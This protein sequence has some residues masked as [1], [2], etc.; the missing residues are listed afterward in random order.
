MSF[1]SPVVAT[2]ACC[3]NR[4]GIPYSLP[5]AEQQQGGAA[6]GGSAKRCILTSTM[7]TPAPSDTTVVAADWAAPS[8]ERGDPLGVCTNTPQS[9][10]LRLFL[11][12]RQEPLDDYLS[13]ELLPRLFAWALPAALFGMLLLLGLCIWCASACLHLLPERGMGY[14][15][16][17]VRATADGHAPALRHYEHT[18]SPPIPLP[19]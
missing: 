5:F 4:G 1:S 10:V 19:T 11:A 8:P 15:P 3:S 13:E 14:T 16:G 12:Y 6:P 9:A 17:R 7:G 2:A 18:P